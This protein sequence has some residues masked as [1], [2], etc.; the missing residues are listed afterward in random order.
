MRLRPVR[1]E[2]TYDAYRVDAVFSPYPQADGN[3]NTAIGVGSPGVYTW[4]G[5]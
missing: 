1:Y 4:R 2:A 3:G 5:T